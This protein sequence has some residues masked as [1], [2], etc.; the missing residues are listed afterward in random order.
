MTFGFLVGELVR[1][2]T[3]TPIRDFFRTEVAEP[4][5]LD[6]WMGLP[7]AEHGRVARVQPPPPPAP[8]EPVSPYL[9]RAMSD[10]QSMQALMIGNTGGY[11]MPG[12]WD[13]PRALEAVLPAVGG[14]GNA[15]SLAGLYRA[16]THDR[17]VGRVTFES[18]DIV[19]MGA[20]RSAL[21]EDVA[22]LSPGRWTLGFMKGAVSPR[23]VE[24]AARIVLS[25]DAFGHMG[26][27]GSIGFADPVSDMSF[28]Y[29]MNQMDPDL[30]VS[31]K[32]QSMID[33]TYRALGYSSAKYGT[34]V[35]DPRRT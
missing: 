6:L 8:G 22:L 32:A 2:V 30:G 12:E 17:K 28:A 16:I 3:G 20:V 33:A 29:V 18:E 25:E 14:V 7:A 13:S 23:G 4:L 19:R 21:T 9:L 26:H 31:E 15:R 24:P 35:A 11:F 10:P 5:G 27:G 34:W 1:R